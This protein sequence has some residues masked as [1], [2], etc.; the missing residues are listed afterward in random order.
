M[1][2]FTNDTFQLNQKLF[3]I[4]LYGTWLIPWHSFTNNV[5]NVFAYKLNVDCTYTEA[6]II[7]ASD[8]TP[9]IFWAFR[10][11][12]KTH[13]WPSRFSIGTRPA[14]PLT[15]VRGEASPRSTFSMYR[16]S[17]SGCWKIFKIL[18]SYIFFPVFN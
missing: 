8:L 16:L 6:H 1:E 18:M 7:I 5:I 9:R 13:I 4:R 10:L 15:T 2:N 3:W 14:K 12:R 11:Q 17:A